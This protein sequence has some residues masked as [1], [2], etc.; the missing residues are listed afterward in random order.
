VGQDFRWFEVELMTMRE[1]FIQH[2][3]HSAGVYQHL[4]SKGERRAKA[5]SREG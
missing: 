1:L 5:F 3:L 2:L 4:P